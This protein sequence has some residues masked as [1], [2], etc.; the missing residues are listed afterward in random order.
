LLQLVEQVAQGQAVDL[1]GGVYKKRLNRNEHRAI[2]LAKRGE[3]WVFEYL[4]AKKDKANITGPELEGFRQI[5]KQYAKLT[6]VHIQQ[7]LDSGYWREIV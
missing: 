3:V 2:I 6:D 1:G 4:F 5:A 7:Q